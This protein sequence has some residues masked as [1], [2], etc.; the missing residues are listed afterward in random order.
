MIGLGIL[1]IGNYFLI[2][3]VVFFLIPEG[4]EVN[5]L[6]L[7][8]VLVGITLEVGALYSLDSLHHVI[9]S[10]ELEGCVTGILDHT[11]FVRII[12]DEE[13]LLITEPR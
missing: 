9:R 6:E 11:I 12:H 8:V 1:E 7:V 3:N 5:Q 10:L 2:Q 4:S 13:N